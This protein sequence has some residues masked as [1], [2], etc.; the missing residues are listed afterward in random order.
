MSTNNTELPPDILNQM[1][2][3]LADCLYEKGKQRWHHTQHPDPLHRCYHMMTP[4]C[5]ARDLMKIGFEYAMREITRVA[6]S[7]SFEELL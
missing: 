7:T 6:D 1:G 4:D 5:V 3:E 2:F